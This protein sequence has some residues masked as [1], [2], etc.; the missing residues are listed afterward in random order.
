MRVLVT[1]GT[2]FLGRYLVRGLRDEHD[3]YSLSR[4]PPAEPEAGVSYIHGDISEI[5]REKFPTSID[6]IIHQA[7]LI[8]NPHKT[9]P[10]LRS[11]AAANV[12]GTLAMLDLGVQLG[13]RRFVHGSSGNAAGLLLEADGTRGPRGPITTEYY[14]LTKYLAEQALFGYDWPF[15]VTSLRYFAPY[16][17]DGSNPLFEHLVQSIRTGAEIE[18]GANGGQSIQPIHISD[19]VG[20]TLKAMLVDKPPRTVDVAGPERVT[21]ARFAELIGQAL[22]KPAILKHGDY[23]TS[24]RYADI[25]HLASTLGEPLVTPAEGIQQEWGL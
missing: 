21:V 1:G 7:A 2:G 12:L 4:R 14:G 5:D 10:P 13:V 11:L 8:D 19:A 20:L 22:G 15:E 16:A 6:V 9:N 3:V 23:Q 18:V 24:S 17:V 25:D